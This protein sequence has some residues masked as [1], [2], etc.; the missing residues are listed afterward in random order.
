MK[1][2]KTLIVAGISAIALGTTY[3]VWNYF[4][5]KNKKSDTPPNDLNNTPPPPS[6][7][8]GTALSTSFPIKFGTYNNKNVAVLQMA[9]K[10]NVDGDWGNKT[11]KAMA[12]Y[13]LAK[14]TIKNQKELTDIIAVIQYKN[15]QS[16][17]GSNPTSTTQNPFSTTPNPSDWL[18]P[19][20]SVR[21]RG[22]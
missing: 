7:G 3:F 4:R 17:G 1:T 2:N 9:L 12:D 5:K 18:D 10:V 13:S 15:R 8:G 21:P 14:T 19:T 6:T 11:E 22:L 20:I 16:E